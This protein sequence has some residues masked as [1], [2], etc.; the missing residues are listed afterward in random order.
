MVG[1]I[2]EGERTGLGWG[3]G[4]EDRTCKKKWVDG[5]SV[6]V[7]T[8]MTGSTKYERLRS[9]LYGSLCDLLG[10]PASL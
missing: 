8:A 2:K 5:L 10:D 9:T 4:T 1:S 7:R 3:G 6:C